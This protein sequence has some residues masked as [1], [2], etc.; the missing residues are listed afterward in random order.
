MFYYTHYSTIN[1]P[2]VF[3]QADKSRL[4]TSFRLIVL[5]LILRCLAINFGHFT[6]VGK[7]L[8]AT[9]R[10]YSDNL[11]QANKN[12]ANYREVSKIYRQTSYT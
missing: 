8:F 1:L 4:L 7:I 9:F 11:L 6:V 12:F 10:L 3:S 5:F 2:K